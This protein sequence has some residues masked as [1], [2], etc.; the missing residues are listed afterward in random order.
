MPEIAR[1]SI[2]LEQALDVVELELRAERLA[3]A[4]AQL[5]DDAAR[6]L[7]V[8]FAGHLHGGV[9]AVIASPQRPPQQ[10]APNL[11]KLSADVGKALTAIQPAMEE[12]RK[13]LQKLVPSL[14]ERLEKLKAP[15]G[16]DLGAITPDEIAISILAEIVA[17]RRS[18]H[19]R[20]ASGD[21]R[22]T[23]A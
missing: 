3:E 23:H 14:A 19:S 5:L 18:R 4:A 1:R 22:E 8:D 12:A 10:A 7:G 13:E 2:I 15:A 20:Q 9:V 21:A 16:L 17:V 11:E 6:P